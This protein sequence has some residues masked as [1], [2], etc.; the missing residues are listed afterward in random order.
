[1]HSLPLLAS[2]VFPLP[3]PFPSCHS[4]SLKFLPILQNLFQGNPRLQ[5]PNDSP[6]Q[7]HLTSKRS[8][9]G[10][11][12]HY[13]KPRL[14]QT[15]SRQSGTGNSRLQSQHTP[16]EALYECT[17]R[18]PRE[19]G[20]VHLQKK[21]SSSQNVEESKA[22]SCLIRASGA[23][24]HFDWEQRHTA[25]TPASSQKVS[26]HRAWQRYVE[27]SENPSRIFRKRS[28]PTLREISSKDDLVPRKLPGSASG[29]TE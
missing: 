8:S 1:M 13:R 23:R 16:R 10:Q 29:R 18:I 14:G 3:F 17:Q 11:S 15:S 20:C 21:K 12:L 2:A 9:R 27:I 25:F 22:H 5:P 19:V 7:N 28:S 4:N 26:A 6:L 24:P